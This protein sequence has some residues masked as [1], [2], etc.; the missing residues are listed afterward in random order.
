MILTPL[1]FPKHWLTTYHELTLFWIPSHSESPKLLVFPIRNEFT[2]F[3]AWKKPWPLVT[4]PHHCR[5]KLSPY[6]GRGSHLFQTSSQVTGQP[7]L[8]E[9]EETPA[10]AHQGFCE[11]TEMRRCAFGWSFWWGRHKHFRVTSNFIFI[12]TN[13]LNLNKINFF[14]KNEL[15]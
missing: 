3:H 6:P 4:P 14:I 5:L 9:T 11:K 7:G 2:L 15:F 13:H 12:A 8:A 10:A 1:F